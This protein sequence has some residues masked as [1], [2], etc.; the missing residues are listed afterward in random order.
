MAV[1][2]PD[3]GREFDVSLFEYG[4]KVICPCGREL[5][6]E[7]REDLFKYSDMD[8]LERNIFQSSRHRKERQRDRERMDRIKWEADKI[9]SLILY[10]DM[11]RIDIE[12][13]IRNFREEVLK[14]FPEKKQLLDALY[15]ARFRRLWEQFR[16]GEGKLLPDQDN[17]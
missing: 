16:P 8:E 7:H 11:Q 12:I 5:S 1:K 17:G 4:K 14:K 10:S 3:C 15:L 2:C 6:L 9:S 13:A